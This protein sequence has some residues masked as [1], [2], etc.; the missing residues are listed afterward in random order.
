MRK[1]L[2]YLM[3]TGE[4][5]SK[6]PLNSVW[7]FL[8]PRGF[9]FEIKSQML[10][11]FFIFFARGSVFLKSCSN[12]PKKWKKVQAGLFFWDRPS[13]MPKF[14]GASRQNIV[15]LPLKMPK[16][17]RRFAPDPIFTFFHFFAR[18]GFVFWN[19]AQIFQKISA[20]GL[21]FKMDLQNFVSNFPSKKMTRS[22]LLLGGVLILSPRYSDLWGEDITFEKLITEW[23]GSEDAMVPGR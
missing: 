21:V 15:I 16:I 11:I 10:S 23:T 9:V 18:R 5:E 7:N 14:F 17:F 4:I 22:G 12:L 6:P 13:K 3:T 19:P 8:K 20:R 1:S 2:H